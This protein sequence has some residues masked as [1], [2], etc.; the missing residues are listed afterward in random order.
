MPD[1]NTISG[2]GWRLQISIRPNVGWE[3]SA[4]ACSAPDHEPIQGKQYSNAEYQ[5][6]NGSLRRRIGTL[7]CGHSAHPILL[8]ISRPQYTEKE[9]QK[10][11]QIADRK[12][13]D[14]AA[15]QISPS[16]SAPQSNCA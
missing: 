8:G 2:S 13:T 4:H 11:R 6:L 12:G 7:N 3:I 14:S 15:S 16:C 9:L 1:G 10:L 5:A